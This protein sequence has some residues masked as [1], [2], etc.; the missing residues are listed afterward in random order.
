MRGADSKSGFFLCSVATSDHKIPFIQVGCPI[1]TSILSW[2]NTHSTKHSLL[3]PFFYILVLVHGCSCSRIESTSQ[4]SMTLLGVEYCL[5]DQS[6]N[7]ASCFLKS[8]I[9]MYTWFVSMI[10]IEGQLYEHGSHIL[11][12]HLL[13]GG[14]P[15]MTV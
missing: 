15:R 4:G 12:T 14:V 10:Q 2:T 5:N 13:S 11:E 9:D 8:R 3:Y 7:K 1:Q 6:T